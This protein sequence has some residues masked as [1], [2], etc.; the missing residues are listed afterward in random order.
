MKLGWSVVNGEDHSQERYSIIHG[1]SRPGQAMI[2][3]VHETDV[4]KIYLFTDVRDVTFDLNRGV[5]VKE[6][7]TG[8]QGYGF[9]GK[10]SRHTELND[11]ATADAVTLNQMD[12]AFTVYRA[13]QTEL[14]AAFAAQ[15]M[16][17][18][19]LD[20]AQA[21]E[22]AALT[23]ARSEI[24]LPE[25]QRLIDQDITELPSMVSYEKE[26]AKRREA[27]FD[28]P[29]ADWNTTDLDGKTHGLSDYKGKVV[30]LDFW[31]RGCG[32]CMMA[33][34]QMEQVAQHYAGQPVAVLGMTVDQKPEDAEFVVKKM[35]LTY[36]TLTAKKIAESYK[37][38]AFPTMLIL[39][40]DGVI[41]DIHAGYSPTL[42]EDIEKKIDALLAN[43]SP[44]PSAKAGTTSTS[45][46]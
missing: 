9:I 27:L 12:H 10:R 25:F 33:M 35:G 7:Q 4:D 32:P 1:T 15:N 2:H 11:I 34:P 6:D 5:P 20:A 41:K 24:D 14:Q 3:V 29:A 13:V 17:P 36:I 23:K 37:I 42:R 18:E 22:M 46:H 19:Q 28:S 16:S 44:A 39:D 45:A 38:N 43:L 40:Q 31:Y 26:S 8:S 21:K 30:I